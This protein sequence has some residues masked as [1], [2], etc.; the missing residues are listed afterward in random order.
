MTTRSAIHDLV[1]ALA[2]EELELARQ[3][4][5]EIHEDE[6]AVTT[7]DRD[8]LLER[9]AACDAGDVVNARAFLAAL[10]EDRSYS[11]R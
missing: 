3:A 11:H 10:R 6:V 4:L 8:E 9:Q 7:E 1:D 5:Q 2:D